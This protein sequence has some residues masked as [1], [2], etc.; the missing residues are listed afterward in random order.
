LHYQSKRGVGKNDKHR[1]SGAGYR[2][3]GNRVLC[4]DFDPQAN[5]SFSCG[6]TNEEGSATIYDVV[7][8]QCDAPGAIMRASSTFDMI[9][10]TFC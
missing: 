8:G 10:S 4:I 1:L 6:T 5:L 9:P 3:L 7:K 2:S